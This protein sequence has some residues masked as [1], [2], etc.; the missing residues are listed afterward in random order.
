MPGM[1]DVLQRLSDE[2]ER[3]HEAID[4][5]AASAAAEDRDLSDAER[6]LLARH[7]ARLD[8]LE[9]QIVQLVEIEERR[10]DARDARALVRTGR[11]ETPEGDEGEGNGDGEGEGEGE[12]SPTYRTFAQYARDEILVRFDKA[13]S[14]AGPGAR[15]RAAER[16]QRVVPKVLMADVPGALPTQYLNQI[17][18]LIDRSRPIVEASR[19]VSLTAGKVQIPQITNRPEVAV[20]AAE[21]TEAGD[22]AMTVGFID[23]VATTYLVAANFSWQVIQWSNPDALALWF[24][25]AAESYAKK[26]DAAAAAKLSAADAAPIAV[27]S[28][29]LAG[30]MEAIATAAGE[31]YA[32]TGRY[33]NGIAA[34][35]SVLYTLLGMVASEAPVFVATGS[36]NFSGTFPAIGGL[37]PIPAPG[38]AAD[39]VI[40][41][42]FSALLTAET[43]G[44]PVEL[45]AIEPSIGG[46]EVGII[47]AFLAEV[48]DPGAFAEITPPA[49]GP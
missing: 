11:R 2:R 48:V 38:L 33:V 27:G 23:E 8:Q 14:M 26:T 18:Q 22:G 9:P 39:T 34:H 25:L 42:D 6:D 15:S 32:N 35:P 45:R 47:G 20:Q 44:A 30:W 16:L 21:K 7:R 1:N 12:D 36:G 13:A 17:M 4:E 29:D 49:V 28:A 37:R 31:V 5:V 19:R 41:G 10:R 3:M 43:A 40:V 46:L 24:D